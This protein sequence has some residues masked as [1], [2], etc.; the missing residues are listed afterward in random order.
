[1][2]FINYTANIQQYSHENHH[3]LKILIFQHNNF[4]IFYF[5][6]I[7]EQKTVLTL[8]KR[9]QLYHKKTD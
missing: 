7:S 6:E 8:K 1:M 3:H 2:P 5:F 4:S 9:N